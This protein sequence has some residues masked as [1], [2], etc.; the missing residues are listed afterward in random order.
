MKKKKVVAKKKEKEIT[1]DKNIKFEHRF[2]DDFSIQIVKWDK[3]KFK[4]GAIS[5]ETIYKKLL[6]AWEKMMSKEAIKR[7]NKENFIVKNKSDD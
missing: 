2:E 5:S 4:N 6:P 3:S 1:P 7:F